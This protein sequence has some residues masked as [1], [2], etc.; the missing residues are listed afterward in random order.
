MRKGKAASRRRQ[1][2]RRY[3]AFVHLEEI[4]EQACDNH[5]RMLLITSR[6]AINDHSLPRKRARQRALTFPML[7]LPPAK[8]M[9]WKN[10]TL[11]TDAFRPWLALLC[12][13]DGGD[14]L[15]FLLRCYAVHREE[16][17]RLQTVGLRIDLLLISTGVPIM[18]NRYCP[19][20]CRA[21][22]EACGAIGE[23]VSD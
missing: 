16:E 5:N 2:S 7:F 4:Q 21:H 19:P 1:P 15:W 18:M 11:V 14:S 22:V 6:D 13:V 8:R 9:L 10:R 20:M 17:V 3:R 12:G 23:Q